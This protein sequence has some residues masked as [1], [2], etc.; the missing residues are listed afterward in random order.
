M[1]M[2]VEQWACVEVAAKDEEAAV[3]EARALAETGGIAFQRLIS[4]TG[5]ES[6]WGKMDTALRLIATINFVAKDPAEAL[7]EVRRIAKRAIQFELPNGGELCV[8]P[9][10][11][12]EGTK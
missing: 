6:P 2:Y 11:S 4:A 8:T 10:R 12:R 3:V 1:E 7:E 5:S 9:E